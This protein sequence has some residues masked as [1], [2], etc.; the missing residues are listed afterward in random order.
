[1]GYGDIHHGTSALCRFDGVDESISIHLVTAL[2]DSLSC[3]GVRVLVSPVVI[4]IPKHAFDP[5]RNQYRAEMFLE[6]LDAYVTGDIHVLGLVNLDLYV[7]ELNFIFGLAVRGTNAIV[8]LSRLN[9]IFYKMQPAD[10]ALFESRVLKES[11]HELGHVFGLPHCVDRMCV[12]YFSNSI[13][14]TDSKSDSFCKSCVSSLR[15]AR[16]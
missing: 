11:V 5:T 2:T 8:A 6:A 15:A 13:S 3:I 9:P 4:K 16:K 10:D 1:M 7:P 14:D 12:M